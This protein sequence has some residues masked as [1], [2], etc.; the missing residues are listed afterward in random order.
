MTGDLVHRS[1]ETEEFLH[2]WRLNYRLTS[3]YNPRANLR[4]EL[5]VKVIKRLL[6]ENMRRDRNIDTDKVT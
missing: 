2:K 6:R 1:A 3:A 4:A 5:G